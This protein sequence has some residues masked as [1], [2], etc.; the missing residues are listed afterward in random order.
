[1]T[2]LNNARRALLELEQDARRHDDKFSADRISVIGAY[3]DT[4]VALNI[5][6][7]IPGQPITGAE[8]H[9]LYGAKDA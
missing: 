7:H 5:E 8:F 2:T 6:N 1:M 4:Q 9:Q 3:L